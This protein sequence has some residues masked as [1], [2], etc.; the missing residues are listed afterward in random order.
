MDAQTQGQSQPDQETGYWV[1]ILTGST[2]EE[3]GRMKPENLIRFRVTWGDTDQVLFV[4]R[5]DVQSSDDGLFIAT[6]SIAHHRI[7]QG[8]ATQ[9]VEAGTIRGTFGFNEE[10][11][12]RGALFL[13]DRLLETE[14]AS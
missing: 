8:S 12:P 3:Y 2:Q 10:G 7:G 1:E 13:C 6:G 9:Y 14:E 5:A 4:R 11:F